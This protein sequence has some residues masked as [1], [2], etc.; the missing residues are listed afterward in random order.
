M[1]NTTC[2]QTVKNEVLNLP[3]VSIKQY[4][5]QTFRF[6]TPPS[7]NSPP[8]NWI[9]GW[10]PWSVVSQSRPTSPA[11]SALFDEPPPLEISGEC[12]SR[13]VQ[14]PRPSPR[15]QRA[16]ERSR[17]TCIHRRRRRSA[18]TWACRYSCIQRLCT[19]M[20][21]SIWRKNVCVCNRTISV[22]TT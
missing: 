10:M 1:I 15:N 14:R 16:C 19:N 18:R 11:L 6:T 8:S 9:D 4:T 21:Y 17:A 3:A 2:I 5:C 13:A 20:L 12:R 22:K 7:S